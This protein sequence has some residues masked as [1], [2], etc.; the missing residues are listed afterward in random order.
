MVTFGSDHLLSRTP[1]PSL[2][3]PGVAFHGVGSSISE[4]RSNRHNPSL[5]R[6][7]APLL[8]PCGRFLEVAAKR[9]QRPVRRF[10]APQGLGLFPA[11]QQQAKVKL[12]ALFLK[13]SA[14]EVLKGDILPGLSSGISGGVTA[15]VL[16]EDV[17]A[18]TSA[19]ELY[20]AALKLQEIIRDR[21]S[22]IIVDRT[23][24]ADACN[25]NGV[26]LT[27]RGVPTAV[28]RRTLKGGAVLVGQMVQTVDEARKAAADG[29][30][31]V[32]VSTPDGSVPDKELI[33]Q[34]K[35]K[36]KGGSIPVIAQ[37]GF[38]DASSLRD[39][40]KSGADGLALDSKLLVVGARACGSSDNVEPDEAA[41][42]ILQNLSEKD[43]DVSG[44]G[45]T[46]GKKLLSK[47]ADSLV[48]EEKALV[49]KILAMLR[50]VSPE[51]EEIGLL[52]S[53]LKQLDELFLVVVVGE[54]N[55]GKSSVINALLGDK[56]LEEGI[57][58]TTNEVSIL[59]HT[60]GEQ[61]NQTNA[62]GIVEQFL[63]AD[64]LREVSIVDTPGTNVVLQRQQRLTEEYVPRADMVLFVMSADRPFAESEVKFL[65][66]IRRWGK[67]V[68]FVVNKVDILGGSQDVDEVRAFVGENAKDLLKLD[69]AFV[70]PVSAK[71]AVVAKSG[72]N[73]NYEEDANWKESRFQELEEFIFGFFSGESGAF[74][75]ESVRLK[76]QTPLFVADALMDACGRQLE[77]ELASA[78]KD[79]AAVRAVRRQLEKFRVE[80]VKDSVVQRRT[81]RDL[82][83]KVVSR[84][85]SFVDDTLQL[86]RIQT[87]RGY[88]SSGDGASSPDLSKGFGAVAMGTVVEDLKQVVDEHDS[89]LGKNF[90]NQLENYF[91]FAQR[92]IDQ[93]NL[94]LDQALEE[95]KTLYKVAKEEELPK[96]SR[97]VDLSENGEPTESVASIIEKVMATP[98][99]GV[100]LCERLIEAEIRDA[101]NATAG[102]AIAAVGIGLV[103]TFILPY[104]SEDFLAVA[105]SLV[106]GYVALLNLPLRRGEVKGKV[107]KVATEV[108]KE[109]DGGMEEDLS[110]GLED[111]DR[112]VLKMTA[113]LEVIFEK[114]V[115]RVKAAESARADL[116]SEL[117]RF[118]SRVASI[119]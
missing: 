17:D 69:E 117:E 41:E 35:I 75:G 76:L 64:L 85:E 110:T 84:I 43:T 30:N 53:A 115:E 56:F 37:F 27:P 80:M 108:F 8:A 36:Q 87:L 100:E 61:K 2:L 97:E 101:V 104:T 65:E 95:Y 63:P 28:A 48:S 98:E 118:K 21:A 67:K 105:L 54:F 111:C 10:A 23:D 72:Q 114:D 38:G 32:V 66:Y 29:A 60:D 39:L 74:S 5:A 42:I 59:R 52:D 7:K 3:C 89:W 11:G 57:L 33:A 106:I 9:A 24:I 73:P 58:P 46:P 103:L 79:L 18:S 4:N 99:L 51:M 49:E 12:P 25:A 13:V 77:N 15:V 83:D 93:K 91:E 92:C 50:K 88:L 16:S 62:D 119:E 31:L 68:V 112:Q 22:L 82:L 81:V 45:N 70:W 71:K 107:R 96:G 78:E 6:G 20:D 90:E 47:K 34:S 116:Y 19:G 40:V 113:P 55:S 14:S 44:T 109:V 26:L 102:T 94:S 86:S 1:R